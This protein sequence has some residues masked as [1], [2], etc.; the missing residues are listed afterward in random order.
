MV[1]DTVLVVSVVLVIEPCVK[2]GTTGTDIAV[3]TLTRADA[4]TTIASFFFMFLTVVHL[5]ILLRCQVIK[6]VIYHQLIVSSFTNC[7]V[8]LVPAPPAVIVITPALVIVPARVSFV[9]AAVDT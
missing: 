9:P 6:E 3:G 7:P 8:A 1:S 2:L 5:K 4:T